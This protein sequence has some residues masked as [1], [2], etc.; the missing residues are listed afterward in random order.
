M[1][2]ALIE[3]HTMWLETV[4][5][6]CY[7]LVKVIDSVQMAIKYNGSIL[8]TSPTPVPFTDCIFTLSTKMLFQKQYPFWNY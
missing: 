5:K 6:K 8:T 7:S 1:S 2:K 4:S 3:S